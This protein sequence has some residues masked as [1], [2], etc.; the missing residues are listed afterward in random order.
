MLYISTGKPRI[1]VSSKDRRKTGQRSLCPGHVAHSFGR[2]HAE[3]SEVESVQCFFSSTSRCRRTTT[4]GLENYLGF[5]VFLPTLEGSKHNRP[6]ELTDE[7]GHSQDIAFFG[8]LP[9]LSDLST[10]RSRAHLLS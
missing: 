10:S 4:E 7:T 1:P 9:Y 2:R 6:V 8:P 3:S 5:S